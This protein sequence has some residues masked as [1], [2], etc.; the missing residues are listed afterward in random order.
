LISSKYLDFIDWLDILELQNANPLT[1]SY[2]D[3]AIKVRTDF[4]STR[5][6]FTWHHLRNCYLTKP[7]L[8]TTS[9]P[10]NLD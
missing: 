10:N 5:T 2:L 4:N 1:S 8:L 6:T 3:K 9:K 7:T